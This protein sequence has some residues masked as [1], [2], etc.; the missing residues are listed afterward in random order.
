[1]TTPIHF[2]C[3]MR[4][5]GAY[6]AVYVNTLKAAVSRHVKTPFTFTVLTDTPA[7]MHSSVRAVALTHKWPGWWSKIELFRPNIWQS[8]RV[9]YLDLDTLIT[10]D[11]DIIVTKDLGKDFYMLSDFMVPERMASG[12][13]TWMANDPAL[14]DVYTTFATRPERVMAACSTLG[15]QCWIGCQGPKAIPLQSV[16]PHAFASLRLDCKNG[17]PSKH[18]KFVCFHGLPRPHQALFMPE[19]GWVKDHWKL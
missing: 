18:T 14:I 19:F 6:N 8:G 7:R 13:M 15:D 16:F 2:A 10:N 4:T 11:A 3:V 1:M 9:W 5:G 17:V 12:V